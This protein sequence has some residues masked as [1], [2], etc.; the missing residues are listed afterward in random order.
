MP[1]TTASHVRDNWKTG[2]VPVAAADWIIVKI[3]QRSAGRHH[4]CPVLWVDEKSR[5]QRSP[6]FLSPLNGEDEKKFHCIRVREEQNTNTCAASMTGH[7]FQWMWFHLFSSSWLPADKQKAHLVNN[8][9]E[10]GRYRDVRAV[11]SFSQDVLED[12]T[13]K[14]INQLKLTEKN[15]SIRFKLLLQPISLATLQWHFMINFSDTS[16]YYCYKT[17]NKTSCVHTVLCDERFAL[18]TLLQQPTTVSESSRFF[19]DL[20]WCTD[21]E[22]RAYRSC[23]QEGSGGFPWTETLSG[24]RPKSTGIA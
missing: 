17:D 24:V 10:Q 11:G 2:F 1:P 8:L 16:M 19:Y 7:V 6:Q 18:L 14:N 13:A 12:C 15:N 3:L 22:R 5:G 20:T 23:T 21:Q 9:N 4:S